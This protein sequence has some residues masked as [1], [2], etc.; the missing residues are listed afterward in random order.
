MDKLDIETYNKT[1]EKIFVHYGK[2]EDFIGIECNQNAVLTTMAFGTGIGLGVVKK[3]VAMYGGEI[4][5][6]SE[7]NKGTTFIHHFPLE[8]Q[9]EASS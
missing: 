7:V 9:E 8:T 3:T 2:K 4:E 5:V 1:G 6:E